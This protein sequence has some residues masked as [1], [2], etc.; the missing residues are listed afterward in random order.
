MN[1]TRNELL[2]K[3]EE[4]G[5]SKY[6]SKNK[7]ELINM[8]NNETINKHLKPLIKWSGGKSD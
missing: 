7:S 6:K 2:L 1:L 4:L 3:C 8:I 5:F